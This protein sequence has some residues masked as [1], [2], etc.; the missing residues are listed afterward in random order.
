MG[1]TEL[2]PFTYGGVFK[3]NQQVLFIDTQLNI[4]VTDLSFKGEEKL[5]EVLVAHNAYVEI[6]FP[7]VIVDTAANSIT[8]LK[9]MGELDIISVQTDINGES[10]EI[11][12]IVTDSTLFARGFNELSVLDC[13]P[14]FDG[15]E[16]I[17]DWVEGSG[18]EV[19]SYIETELEAT[20]NFY[21]YRIQYDFESVLEEMENLVEQ[22][23]LSETL[24]A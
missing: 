6:K 15:H 1:T 10:H 16:D 23:I 13:A 14:I 9:E 7:I 17:L 4:P 2:K 5:K 12:N 21:Q 20:G 3:N 11:A 8:Y 18:K 24:K 19:K 22:H